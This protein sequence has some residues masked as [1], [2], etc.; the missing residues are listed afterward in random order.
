MAGEKVRMYEEM[1]G[2]EEEGWCGDDRPDTIAHRVLCQGS[3]EA[4]CRHTPGAAVLLAVVKAVGGPQWEAR[5]MG[6][7]WLL[8]RRLAFEEWEGRS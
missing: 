6:E 5:A 7:G 3:E 8:L 2:G 4:A 1:A